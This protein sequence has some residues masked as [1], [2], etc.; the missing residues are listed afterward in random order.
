MEQ[1]GALADLGLIHHPG[2]RQAFIGIIED[3]KVLL[4]ENSS[5]RLSEDGKLSD[6]TEYHIES[7]GFSVG[8]FARFKI[9]GKSI[10][11]SKERGLH[12]WIYDKNLGKVVDSVNYDTYLPNASCDLIVKDRSIIFHKIKV[13]AENIVGGYTTDRTGV[14]YVNKVRLDIWDAEHP[15]DVESVMMSIKKEN[16]EGEI[17]KLH[18][19]ID[20]R[21]YKGKKVYIR[22][23]GTNP[24]G[25][26]YVLNLVSREIR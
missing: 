14:H 24:K 4:D 8:R 22:A 21:K 13:D 19:D 3:G 18:A 25:R 16:D 11:D 7:Q 17:L 15:D 2:F 12:I 5:D 23:V 6:G 26:E 1:R 10:F 9:N 20:S